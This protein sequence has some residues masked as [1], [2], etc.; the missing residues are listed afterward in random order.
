MKRKR[1]QGLTA[2]QRRYAERKAAGVCQRCDAKVWAKGRTMCADH[3]AAARE[4]ASIAQAKANPRAARNRRRCCRGGCEDYAEEGGALCPRHQAD[5]E[6]E[7]RL[8]DENDPSGPIRRGPKV[9]PDSFF[10]CFGD[11][12]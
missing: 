6:E 8:R 4:R 10:A 7:A 9:K 5:R 11:A 1:K 12:S 2:A 3:A